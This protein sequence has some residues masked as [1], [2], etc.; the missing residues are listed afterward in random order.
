M[1]SDQPPR[2]EVT[3][4][5]RGLSKSYGGVHALTDVNFDVAKGEVHAI[6]GENGAGKSTLLNLFSGA[7]RPDNGMIELSGLPVTFHNPA[8]AQAAGVAMV[9]QEL[10]LVPSLSVAENLLLGDEPHFGP[11]V[12]KRQLRL[13][14]RRGLKDVGAALNLD[15]QVGD[16]SLAEQ[17]RV[18]IARA[19]LRAPKVMILDEPTT[20]LGPDD[21]EHLFSLVRR[22]RSEGMAIIFVSHR[23]T[24]V[25]AIADRVTVLRDGEVV[26]ELST[27]RATSAILVKAMTG[28]NLDVT[29]RRTT[30]RQDSVVFRAEDIGIDLGIGT[31]LEL[32]AGEVVGIAGLAGAGRSSLLRHMVGEPWRGGSMSVGDRT[33][34]KLDMVTALRSGV[35]YIPEDRKTSGLVL[36]GTLQF[37]VSL[38][39][40]ARRRS[41]LTSARRDQAVYAPLGKKL[42]IKGR[43]NDAV[44]KLSGGNQQK[45]LLARALAAQPKVL[46]LDEPTR[47]VDIAT[48]EEIWRLIDELAS[49][50]TSVLIVSSELPEI[51]RLSDRILVM[52]S[53]RVVA[54]L[55]GSCSEEEILTAALPPSAH[56]HSGAAPQHQEGEL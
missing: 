39:A 22:F 55:D 1:T 12:N 28:R 38:S 32:H 50:G 5:A 7:T 8:D 3:L 51:L 36:D 21:V 31:D 23:F 18:A 25:L 2:R 42:R 45:V 16:L 47:G 30:Q 37:N 35:A 20:P 33:H 17:Q 54:E 46:L 41:V 9:F 11:F 14:A 40:T 27:E 43:P 4:A 56:S 29:S 52:R 19:A 15:S 34:R 26:T 44:S 24:E 48:K 53:G 49:S 6:V 10:D 13:Q